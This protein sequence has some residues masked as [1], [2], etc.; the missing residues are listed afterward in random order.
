[1]WKYEGMLKHNIQE[2]LLD[3]MVDRHAS[4]GTVPVGYDQPLFY[5]KQ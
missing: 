5:F 2:Q 3:I 4:I 1:M